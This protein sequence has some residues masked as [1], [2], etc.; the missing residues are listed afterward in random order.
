MLQRFSIKGALAFV[1]GAVLA[2]VVALSAYAMSAINGIKGEFASVVN[3]NVNLLSTISDL[4]YY[5]VTYRRFALDYGLTTSAAEHAQIIRVIEA[6]RAAVEA[7]LE[8]MLELAESPDVARFVN[9]YRRRIED[10][11]VMQENYIRLIDDGRIEEARAMILGPM[12]APFNQIVDLLSEIQALIVAEAHAIRD[13]QTQA[14]ERVIYGV[15]FG[16]V[17]IVVFTSLMWLLM[18][19]K[20]SRP[21]AALVAQM[22]RVEQGELDT[23]LDQG[24]FARD[25]LGMCARHFTRMQEGIRKL[26]AE[27]STSAG[28]LDGSVLNV[29]QLADQA[30]LGMQDQQDEVSQMAAATGQMQGTFVDVANSTTEAADAARQALAEADR[31]NAT[32]QQAVQQIERVAQDIEAAAAVI[33]SLHAESASIGMVLDVIRDVAEQTNLLAL[34]AAIEAARAGEQGRGFA[35]VADEV[36]NLAQ[37]TQTSIAEIGDTIELLQARAAEAEN[38]M[39]ESREAMSASV[40]TARAAAVSISRIHGA[41]DR[42]SEMNARIATATEEQTAVAAELSRGASRVH[43]VATGVAAGSRETARACAELSEL[44]ASLKGLTERFRL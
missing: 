42:I 21:L 9:D 24:M 17:L 16:F 18:A 4:R 15:A 29:R 3:E 5:T 7:S 6:N 2:A 28:T 36:R 1:V 25:E 22:R 33:Q 35:V 23:L 38:V 41:V 39:Q 32:V 20:I 11:R 19:R 13:S 44:A 8:R 26:V 14:I 31:G 37:R 30:A 40:D 43:E 34:N 12:L 27:I 10:Y